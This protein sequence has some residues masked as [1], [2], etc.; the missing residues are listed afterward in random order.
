M[1]ITIVGVKFKNS[2]KVYYF[3]PEANAYAEGEGVIVETARGV[4][5]GLVAIAN[6]DVPDAEVVQPLKPII[7]KATDDDF[8]QTIKN[9]GMKAEAMRLAN[10]KIEKHKLNM[11]LVDAEYTFDRNK[12]IFYF[13]AN[14]RVDFRELVKD[15]AGVF[16]VRIELRQ[17]Y[18]R[19]DTKIR[20]ALAVCGRECCCKTHLPDF[21]KVSIKMAKVQGLSLNPAKIS[22]VCGRLMC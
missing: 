15:L 13:T 18:E 7:R 10:E 9:E 8:A 11:K 5:Y 17:I 22:G 6:R 19:D 4:E 21:E 2:C 14:G 12:V 16:R 3:N 20:G 1:S